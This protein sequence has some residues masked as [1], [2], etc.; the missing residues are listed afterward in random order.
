[1]VRDGGIW[2]VTIVAICSVSRDLF[3]CLLSDLLSLWLKYYLR[4]WG[5]QGAP[6]QL[7]FGLS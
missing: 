5:S 2:K 4:S 6:L 3:A 7:C 1:M